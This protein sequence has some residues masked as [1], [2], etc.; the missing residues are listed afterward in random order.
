MPEGHPGRP[1]ALVSPTTAQIADGLAIR[2]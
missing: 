2:W 1:V